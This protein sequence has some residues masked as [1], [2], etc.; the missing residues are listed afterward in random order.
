[1]KKQV[2]VTLFGAKGKRTLNIATRGGFLTRHIKAPREAVPS[3]FGDVRLHKPA[4]TPP[5]EVSAPSTPTPVNPKPDEV[6]PPTLLEVLKWMHA[7]ENH[8]NWLIIDEILFVATKSQ[9]IA[10]CPSIAV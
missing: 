7:S 2:K 4:A 1:M 5:V 3:L 8:T 6:S 10:R 9:H